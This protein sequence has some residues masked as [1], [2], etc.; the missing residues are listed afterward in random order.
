MKLANLL[1]IETK[2]REGLSNASALDRAV[3]SEFRD[4]IPALDDLACRLLTSTPPNP[5]RKADVISE[6][7]D[8]LVRFGQPLHVEI[9]RAML[10]ARDPSLAVPRAELSIWLRTE[11]EVEE[12]SDSVFLATRTDAH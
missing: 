8:L 9:L 5:T 1:S 10:M 11:N 3:I 7:I 4:R 2:G 6:A 12:V